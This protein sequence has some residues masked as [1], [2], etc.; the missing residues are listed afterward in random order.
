MEETLR[1]VP[2]PAA[3][4]QDILPRADFQHRDKN[5]SRRLLHGRVPLMAAGNFSKVKV[6]QVGIVNFEN[7]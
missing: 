6:A 1:Q 7:R 2:R 5:L 4:V 3:E